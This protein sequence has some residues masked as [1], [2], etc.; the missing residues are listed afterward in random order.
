[1]LVVL[2]LMI[3]AGGMQLATSSIENSVKISSPAGSLEINNNIEGN[4]SFVSAENDKFWNFANSLNMQNIILLLII[5][6]LFIALIAVVWKKGFC[7]KIFREHKKDKR[8]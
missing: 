7:K 4:E 2:T 8:R 1:M 6:G 5:C 3:I